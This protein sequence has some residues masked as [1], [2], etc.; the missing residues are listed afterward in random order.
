MLLIIYSTIYSIFGYIILF[1][2]IFLT[3][4]FTD[5]LECPK[6]YKPAV[7]INVIWI[8][9]TFFV[10]RFLSSMIIN[11]LTTIGLD[12]VLI[13][14]VSVINSVILLFIN[15][16]V[17]TLLINAFYKLGIKDSIFITLAI[18][19][20]QIFI[21]IIIANVLSIIFNITTGGYLLLYAFQFI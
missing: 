7:L 14:F 12:F 19:S 18:I 1:G 20:I 15:F 3:K 10:F 5:K 4:F 21:Q 13:P 17:I 16:L 9:M 11:Y 6:S 8:L 2:G